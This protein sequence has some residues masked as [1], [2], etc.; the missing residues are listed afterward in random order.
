MFRRVAGAMLALIVSTGLAAATS[1][2]WHGAN[3]F[4][5]AEIKFTAFY[6]NQLTDITG[7]MFEGNEYSGRYEGCCGPS[8]GY[9]YGATPAPQTNFTLWLKLG[10]TADAAGTWTSILT[11][12]RPGGWSEAGERYMHDLLSGP[13][14]FAASYVTGI[15]LTSD[16]NGQP[17]GDYNFTNFNYVYVYYTGYGYHR[18][19]HELA[20]HTNFLFASLDPAPPPAPVPVPAALP[21]LA[22]GLLGG[23]AYGKLRKRF[24]R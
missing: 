22:S 19:R 14:G 11:W 8:Y 6:S 17:S 4:N 15:R 18:E 23:A 7:T 24:R 9:P 3:E 20:K 21:L 16:P 13:V 12:N 2:T 1:V 10:A 5:D